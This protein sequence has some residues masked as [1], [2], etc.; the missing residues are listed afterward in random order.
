MQWH[1]I[2]VHYHEANLDRLIVEGVRPFT[3]RIAGVDGVAAAYVVRHW[4]RGPH[5]RLNVRATQRAFRETVLTAAEQTLGSFLAA[6]PSAGGIDAS[7]SA[8]THRRLAELERE[9]G[10]LVPWQPDNTL[11]IAPYDDRLT[12]VR[13]VAAAEHRAE[14]LS[15][16]TPLLFDMTERVLNGGTRRLAIAFDLMIATAH[17]MSGGGVI[18]GLSSF[19]SH[20]EA[21]LCRWPE[22]QGRRAAWDRYHTRHAQALSQRVHLVTR[23][24][25]QPMPGVPEIP[26][27]APWVTLLGT[28]QI[29]GLGLIRAG[30]MT[31]PTPAEDGQNATDGLRLVDVSPYHRVVWANPD[32]Q[33]IMDSPWLSAWRLALNY[34]YLQ[35][36]RLGVGPADRFLLCHLAANAIEDAYGISAF[37]IAR[38]RQARERLPETMA[39]GV[40]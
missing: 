3:E 9:E 35:T 1:S 2:H 26:F 29:H 22:G 8:D 11:L 16:T 33:R 10:P 38:G 18:T 30:Q 32:W 27:V 40:V 24:L 13:T 20:A 4:L 31:M 12:A 19:R 25:D 23:C 17:R 39:E 14:F 28:S 5:L 34:L 37:D 21:F 6:H 36:T 7:S 15:A